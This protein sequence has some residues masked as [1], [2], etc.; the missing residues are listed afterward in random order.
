MEKDSADAR[1]GHNQD[2]VFFAVQ[3]F[4]RSTAMHDGMRGILAPHSSL[5]AE[6]VAKCAFPDSV[7]EFFVWLW[8]SGAGGA[9]CL[10][11]SRHSPCHSMAAFWVGTLP[12][13]MS[14][15]DLSPFARQPRIFFARNE[16]RMYHMRDGPGCGPRAFRAT[17]S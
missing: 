3:S 2:S 8:A 7:T 17:M 5:T 4:S 10:M 15:K 14:V 9:P 16:S 1:E 6:A 13:H 12:D 11:L